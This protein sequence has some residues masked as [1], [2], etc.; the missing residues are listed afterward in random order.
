M[1]LLIKP[2]QFKPEVHL[3]YD[4]IRGISGD[5]AGAADARRVG[6]RKEQKVP[7]A[8]FL[9]RPGSSR[10]VAVGVTQLDVRYFF[11]WMYWTVAVAVAQLIEYQGSNPVIGNFYSL[12]TVHKSRLLSQLI[13]K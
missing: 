5:D 13:V 12:F 10:L 6:H 2:R 1:L 9:F 3:K 8:F 7:Q 4:E 11:L